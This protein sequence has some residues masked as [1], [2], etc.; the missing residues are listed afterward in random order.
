MNHILEQAKRYGRQVA[1]LEDLDL[2]DDRRN[3]RRAWVTFRR[4]FSTDYPK[5][6]EDIV[7]AYWDAY[8]E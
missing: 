1:Q 3:V 7:D 2:R 6:Y 5:H 4:Q 8:C